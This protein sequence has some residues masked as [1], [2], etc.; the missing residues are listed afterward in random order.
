[1]KGRGMGGGSLSTMAWRVVAL[2]GLVALGGCKSAGV[3]GKVVEGPSSIVTLADLKDSR[4]EGPG[5]AGA[6]AEL[7]AVQSGMRERSVGTATSDEKG[8]FRLEF[9]DELRSEEL[10]LTV[11][12]DGYVTAK[13]PAS[14]SADGKQVLVVLKKSR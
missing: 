11:T 6:K 7:R 4:F 10:V 12:K 8:K 3:D 5:L 14:I 9:K 2:A 1:M 13:G